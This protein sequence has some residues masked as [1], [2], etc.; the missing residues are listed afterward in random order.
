MRGIRSDTCQDNHVPFSGWQAP[1]LPADIGFVH[2]C[3]PLYIPCVPLQLILYLNP[4]LQSCTLYLNIPVHLYP[5]PN[6]LC[7][8]LLYDSASSVN[9]CLWG[10]SLGQGFRIGFGIGVRGLTYIGGSGLTPVKSVMFLFLAGKLQHFVC[11]CRPLCQCIPSAPLHLILCLNCWWLSHTLNF[12][13]P[14]HLYSS[15]NTLCSVLLYDLASSVLYV[16][17]ATA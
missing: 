15:P 12:Y 16:H 17:E 3:R 5:W 6:T 8:V 10:N 14:L 7:H 2:K 13:I 4:W 1:A 11:K 9:I